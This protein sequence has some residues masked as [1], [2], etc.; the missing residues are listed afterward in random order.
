MADGEAV[1][2]S[3]LSSIDEIPDYEE[4]RLLLLNLFKYIALTE[5][6][7][8][9]GLDPANHNLLRAKYMSLCR[10]FA[11]QVVGLPL[12]YDEA[13]SEPPCGVCPECVEAGVKP[14]EPEP[15]DPTVN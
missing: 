12:L 9:I 2:Y 7:N 11:L 10:V 13:F 6:P 15:V 1:Y 8:G 14:P 4:R 5:A 3:V